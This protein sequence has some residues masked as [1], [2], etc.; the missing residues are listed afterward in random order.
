MK[1]YPFRDGGPGTKKS[2]AEKYERISTLI[3]CIY[4]RLRRYRFF[5]SVFF[6]KGEGRACYDTWI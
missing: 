6:M 1:E 5:F 2:R 4:V 3:E